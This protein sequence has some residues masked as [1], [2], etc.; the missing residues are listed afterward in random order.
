MKTKFKGIYA[1]LLIFV[2]AVFT[3]SVSYDYSEARRSGF[4]GS[5][6]KYKSSGS[7]KKSYSPSK[8]V[9]GNRSGGGIFGSKKSSSGYQKPG[10][11]KPSGT[12][13]SDYSKPQKKVYNK[14][15]SGY[16]KPG[17]RKGSV[18]KSGSGFDQKTAKNMKKKK[19][20]SSFAA[21]KAEKNRYKKTSAPVNSTDSY[22]KSPIL[23]NTKTYSNN[24]Y[25]THYNTRDRYYS[26]NNWTRPAYVFSSMPRFGMWD[27]LVWWMILDNLGSRNHYAMAHHHSEDPGYKEWRKEAEQLAA[28]NS[29]LAE[30]LDRLDSKLAGMEGE[31]K[32]TGYLPDGMPPEVAIAADVLDAKKPEKPEFILATA[33][34]TGTYH[35][36][37]KLLKVNAGELSVKLRTTAGSMENI[38]LL[39]NGDIDAAI[40]QS[41]AFAVYKQKFPSS[42]LD[43]TEQVPLYKEAVQMIANKKS[44]I[45][46]VKDLLPNGRHILYIGPKGSGTAMTWSGFCSQDSYYKKIAVRHAPYDIALEQVIND[47]NSV[48]MFVSGLNSRILKTAEQEA[49]K[50]KTIRLVEV[51]DWNFNNASDPFGNKIYKFVNIPSD[52]YP[53]LQKTFV[54]FGKEIETIAVE[55]ILAMRTDWAQKYGPESVDAL[56]FAVME[57][58]P[59]IKNLTNGLEK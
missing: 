53:A 56:S 46:S 34:E 1:A 45:N 2:L 5:G 20:A 9:W 27:A 35:K 22:N 6:F 24:D 21:Y 40:V 18:F 51:N 14:T 49:A 57:T 39:I 37:G 16:Q 25:R 48:M 36:F 43:A 52:T 15:S 44:D 54:F 10:A 33:S 11:K 19:A 13:S 8:S 12:T 55:A 58:Q 4:R 47:K 42:K 50:N 28:T 17:S 23:N 38:E 26:G 31:P 59:V 30:K 7:W 32:D 29:D 3:V 41:D